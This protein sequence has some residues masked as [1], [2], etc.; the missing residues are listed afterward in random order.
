MLSKWWS[1]MLKPHLPGGSKRNLLPLSMSLESLDSIKRQEK[2]TLKTVQPV[3]LL[4]SKQCHFSNYLHNIGI[5]LCI[6]N[7]QEMIYRLQGD[8]CRLYAN[9]IHCIKETQEIWGSPRNPSPL[10]PERHQQLHHRFTGIKSCDWR[11]IP[12]PSTSVMP[13]NANISKDGIWHHTIYQWRRQSLQR[14]RVWI[15][16]RP[17][18]SEL[19]L[20]VYPL[21]LPACM[22]CPDKGTELN[23]LPLTHPNTLVIR[24][25]KEC[26]WICTPQVEYLL[27]LICHFAQ[28]LAIIFM[29]ERRA[30]AKALVVSK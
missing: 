20:R 13:W 7:N 14:I 12:S 17:C 8:M 6:I 2:I 27:C 30:E 15:E 5:V 1:S 19:Q 25:Q 18:S 16:T 24:D 4:S 11:F 21:L 3:P 26:E 10:D 22:I 28:T 23:P 9:S 29:A